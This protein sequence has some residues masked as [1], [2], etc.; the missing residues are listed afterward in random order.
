M[1]KTLKSIRY[2]AG[3][4]LAETM[5]LVAVIGLLCAFAIPNIVKSHTSVDKGR[6]PVLVQ[7]HSK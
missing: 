4:T 2:Q 6:V 1:K 7:P 5:I 3:V